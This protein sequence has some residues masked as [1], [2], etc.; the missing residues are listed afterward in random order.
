M[1]RFEQAIALFQ[2]DVR[3]GKGRLQTPALN[4]A[5]KNEPSEGLTG[6]FVIPSGDI[7]G[8]KNRTVS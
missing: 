7:T 2:Q 3:N 8:A 4:G 1:T 5:R 6:G